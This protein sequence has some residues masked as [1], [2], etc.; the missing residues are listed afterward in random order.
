MPTSWRSFTDAHWAHAVKIVG[1]SDG[2]D[3][4]AGCE[5]LAQDTL[6]ETVSAERPQPY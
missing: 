5:K 6:G 1:I 3:L 2:L 4:V